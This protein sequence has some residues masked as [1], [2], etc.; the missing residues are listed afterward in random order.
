MSTSHSIKVSLLV[1]GLM[2]LSS[3]YGADKMSRDE[4]KAAKDKIEAD[5]KAGKDACKDLK[6]NAKDVCLKEAKA[7]EKVAI[8]ELDYKNSGK[9]S[10]RIKAE[11]VKAE[12]DYAVA[13]ERCDDKSGADKSACKAEAKA[14]EKKAMANIKAEKKTASSG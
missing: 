8:A 12:Q 5:F 3:S 2:A 10:D 9:D 13:K 14:A 11:K 7:K 4:Y 6:D 1:A